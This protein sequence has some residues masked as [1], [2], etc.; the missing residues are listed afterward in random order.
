MY[1]YFLLFIVV[2]VLAIRVT[3]PSDLHDNDQ[4]RPAEYIQDLLEKK[5]FF[6]QIDSED[7]AASKPPLYVWIAALPTK[8]LGYRSDLALKSPS[9]LSMIC[10]SVLMIVWGQEMKS[11]LTGI[12]ATIMMWASYH[13]SKL[14]YTNRTDMLLAWWI[15]FSI[16]CIFRFWNICDGKTEGN[17]ERW[18]ALAW[19]S[20]ALGT[21]TK[22]PVAV[23]VPVSSWIFLSLWNR[24]A[25]RIKEIFRLKYFLLFLGIVLAWFLPAL[26]IG[27]EKFYT[28]VIVHEIVD[29]IRGTG[30]RAKEVQPIWFLWPHFIGRF[31]PWSLLSVCAIVLWFRGWKFCDNR[32]FAF[33]FS[34]IFGGLIFFSLVSGKRSDYV[35]PMEPAAAFI[36]AMAAVEAA[37]KK[38]R[39]GDVF[40]NIQD[41]IIAI[42]AACGVLSIL[43]ALIIYLAPGLISFT[44][45]LGAYTRKSLC[46]WL[47]WG[48]IASM[49]TG[50]LYFFR[51]MGVGE[52]AKKPISIVIMALGLVSFLPIYYFSMSKGAK[53]GK[54]DIYRAVAER[55]DYIAGSKKVIYKEGT[56]SLLI[57]FLGG[58]KRCKAVLGDTPLPQMK[59]KFIFISQSLPQPQNMWESRLL[60][61]APYQ[62][63][64]KDK[65]K[66]FL[67]SALRSTESL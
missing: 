48:G 16:Y 3:A 21:L 25:R 35:F 67:V 12:L 20:M 19:V 60:L 2:L 57:Y 36:A 62:K 42:L 6:Y 64:A 46:I 53:E 45:A 58:E 24:E 4:L 38:E 14:L 43:A 27:K 8:I 59:K 28:K 13:G 1:K 51:E 26:I 63:D 31:L 23:C 32:T 52:R 61:E 55:V 65:F 33:L 50:G 56:P 29:R 40:K 17:K 54:A 37:K 7:K 11:K 47:V 10:L 30:P 66:V 34:W 5:H 49:L 39:L 44:A 22:G 41:I 9:I 18:L 15:V